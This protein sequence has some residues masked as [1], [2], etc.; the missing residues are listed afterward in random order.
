MM[1]G[2]LEWRN[3]QGAEEGWF[4]QG[5]RPIENLWKHLGKVFITEVGLCLITAVSIVET[6]AYT[7]LALI[8]IALS[9]VTGRRPYNFFANLLA[10]SSFTVIWGLADI[11]FYNPFMANVMTHESF[12]RYWA[13]MLLPCFS[14][15]RQQDRMHVLD[16]NIGRRPDQGNVQPNPMLA[17]LVADALTTQEWVDRG[18]PF[19]VEMLSNASPHTLTAFH[20]CDTDSEIFMFVLAKAIYTYAVGPKKSELI[21]RF[22]QAAARNGITPLRQELATV[23]DRVGQAL[24]TI[25]SN[26]DT[27]EDPSL[28]KIESQEGDDPAEVTRLN[29]RLN[30]IFQK[31][32]GMA[33]REQNG[34]LLLMRC[35]G[36]ASTQLGG[37]ALLKE[38]DGNDI[39]D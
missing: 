10:S 29:A 16:W 24:A 19:L 39:S 30:S 2:L 22:F 18:T 34:S 26:L 38:Q 8:S 1:T 37:E 13:D 35:W 25:M 28:R 23:D 27:F 12:A 6:I 21:P 17:S 32:R 3:P 11:V 20:A 14:I 5:S 31:L 33:S 4:H 36:P 7:T 15:Y 9:P